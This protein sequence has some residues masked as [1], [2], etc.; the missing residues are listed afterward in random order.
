MA[1]TGEHT[2]CIR[3]LC[4]SHLCR[5]AAPGPRMLPCWVCSHWWGAACGHLC[6]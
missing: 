1:I 4:S 6:V 5:T 2:E 3:L